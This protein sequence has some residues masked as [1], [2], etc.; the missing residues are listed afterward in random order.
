MKPLLKSEFPKFLERFDDFKGSE[1]RSLKI[2]S[3]VE[4]EIILTAQDKA[5][6]YDWLSVTFLFS[7]VI[8][9]KLIDE[10]KLNFLDMDE[11]ITL[12]SEDNLFGFAIGKY[13][14]FSGV[15]NAPLYMIANSLKFN[16]GSF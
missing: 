6:A 3:P 13:H 14:N 16:E 11:G 2:I 9:A 12:I 15:K 5:R 1:I 8:D 4:V 10:K 7:G